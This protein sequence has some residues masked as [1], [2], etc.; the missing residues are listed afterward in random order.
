MKIEISKSVQQMVIP[1][2]NDE[3][4]NFQPYFSHKKNQ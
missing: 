4:Q 3:W 2:S 1:N